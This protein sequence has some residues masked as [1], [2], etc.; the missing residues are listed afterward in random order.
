MMNIEQE[1][2]SVHANLD[3]KKCYFMLHWT[4]NSEDF[5]F[6]ESNLVR[7]SGGRG[8]VSKI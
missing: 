6:L 1:R 2:H 8:T 7:C 5:K 3:K 4:T